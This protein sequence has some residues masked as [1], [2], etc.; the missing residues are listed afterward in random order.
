M[1]LLGPLGPLNPRIL[2]PFDFLY[3]EPLAFR[4]EP[5]T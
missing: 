4:L 5:L 1:R 2:E 3:L